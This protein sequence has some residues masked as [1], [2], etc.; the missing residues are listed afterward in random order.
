MISS[1]RSDPSTEFHT[2]RLSLLRTSNVYTLTPLAS[3]KAILVPSGDHEGNQPSVRMSTD[4]VASTMVTTWCRSP[5]FSNFS[6]ASWSL[7]GDQ[8]GLEYVDTHVTPGV[9]FSTW[10]VS[11]STVY[12]LLLELEPDLS[13]TIARSEL[14]GDHDKDQMLPGQVNTTFSLCVALS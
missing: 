9:R 6:N 10:N 3:T 7:R 12:K 13:A 4:L 8:L 11:R 2:N 14:F 1:L 5:A